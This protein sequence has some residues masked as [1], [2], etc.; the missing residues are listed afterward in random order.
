MINRGI[1]ACGKTWR[2]ERVAMEVEPVESRG[3]DRLEGKVKRVGNNDK[4]VQPAKLRASAIR[5]Y[6]IGIEETGRLRAADGPRSLLDLVSMIFTIGRSSRVSVDLSYLPFLFSRKA[7]RAAAASDGSHIRFHGKEIYIEIRLKLTRMLEG[8]IACA[9]AASCLGGRENA[10]HA[11][12][13]QP[14][15]GSWTFN[16]RP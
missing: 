10:S 4:R 1:S 3:R 11:P 12:S 9:R 2:S 16:L 6:V 8:K 15:V 13:W 5:S 7:L 14:Y